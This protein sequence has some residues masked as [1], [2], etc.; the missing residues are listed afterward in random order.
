ME[1][2]LRIPAGSTTVPAFF[3]APDTEGHLS[4][5]VVIH[6][7][8][9]LN[10]DIR[11]ITRRLAGE[12]YAALA[13]DL[14]VGTAMDGKVDPQLIQDMQDPAKKDA[15]QTR[16]RAVLAPIHAPEFA[17]DMLRKLRACVEKLH[18]TCGNIAVMGFCF[19][20]TYSFMLAAEEPILKAAVCFYGHPPQPQQIARIRCP[21]LALY[22]EKDEALMQSLPALRDEMN[23]QGKQFE[24]HVYPDAGH[25]FFN[26][27]N[28]QRYNKSAAD[29]AW[30]KVK[31][32]LK[33]NI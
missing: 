12:G 26:K 22:G 14:L 19:G 13:P 33:K 21:V 9:G 10:D 11:D 3:A 27:W 16:L 24:S 18:E 29:D 32:F 4:G 25:A 17:Q 28:P 7:I 20:G 30:E 5:I 31:E 8:W 23:K 2:D 1:A 15:A 6:E